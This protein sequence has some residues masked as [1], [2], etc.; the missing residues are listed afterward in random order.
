MG[1]ISLTGS[2][3]TDIKHVVIP[4]RAGMNYINHWI[5]AFAGMTGHG[6]QLAL[7]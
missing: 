4:A 6:F 1:L 3:P 7:E 5:P 2:G